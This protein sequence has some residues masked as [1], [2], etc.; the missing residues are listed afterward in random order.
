[1]GRTNA[2]LLTTDRGRQ[3]AVRD[4]DDW[5]AERRLDVSV[6]FWN[7]VLGERG[8]YYAS[9]RIGPKAPYTYEVRLLDNT[10]SRRILHTVQLAG[11]SPGLS[12]Q[13]D[14]KTVLISGVVTVG[15]DLFRIENFR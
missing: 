6:V 5:R 2:V 8:L 15:Q 11:M 12:V 13:P 9:Q 10:G 3:N 14:G 4:A 1:V 7:Y